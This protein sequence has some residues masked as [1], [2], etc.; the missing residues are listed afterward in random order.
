M[1]CAD[2]EKV[3]STVSNMDF[4]MK[5]QEGNSNTTDISK[6]L[7]CVTLEIL[8]CF[9]VVICWLVTTIHLMAGDCLI[10][11]YFNGLSLQQRQ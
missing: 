5:L 8:A 6:F 4:P 7:Q 1:K 10:A 11:E 2:V 3:R 9:Y